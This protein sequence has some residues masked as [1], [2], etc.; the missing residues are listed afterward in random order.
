MFFQCP[1]GCWLCHL[2]FAETPLLPKQT[3]QTNLSAIL[4]TVKSTAHIPHT[5]LSGHLISRS[6]TVCFFLTHQSPIETV[7][8]AATGIRLTTEACFGQ[9]WVL[10]HRGKSSS[11]S[12]KRRGPYSAQAPSAYTHNVTTKT[13]ASDIHVV[14]G[15]PNV[16][17]CIDA[18]NK[19]LS[20]HIHK[21]H[22]LQSRHGDLSKGST[23]PLRRFFGRCLFCVC[24]RRIFQA[25]HEC[26][27]AHCYN[28]L[29]GAKTYSVMCGMELCTARKKGNC[30]VL[31]KLRG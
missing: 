4:S 9:Y 3:P 23:L 7:H 6:T 1:T 26:A 17:E 16:Q 24:C 12:F 18:N 15:N 27:R 2:Q 20:P 14:P 30:F 25:I 5:N 13:T 11:T 8:V 29:S 19:N 28:T 10:Q 21:T 22:T 31:N